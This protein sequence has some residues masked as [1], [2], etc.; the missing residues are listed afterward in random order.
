[1]TCV[2]ENDRLVNRERFVYI[3]DGIKL[4]VISFYINIKLTNGFQ[5]YFFILNEYV[6]WTTHKLVC[7]LKWSWTSIMYIII[8]SRSYI[9]GHLGFTYNLTL[10]TSGGRVAVTVI[11]CIS[12]GNFMKMSFTC[13]SKPLDNI[14]STSSNTSILMWLV[15]NAPSAIICFT[16]PGVPVEFEE[17]INT[18]YYNYLNWPTITCTPDASRCLMSCTFSPPTTK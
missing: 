18:A 2:A 14:T 4:K 11:A 10:S 8:F 12:L 16:R 7:Y 1:M 17:P 15:S 3:T 5:R 13:S 9:L 6:Q